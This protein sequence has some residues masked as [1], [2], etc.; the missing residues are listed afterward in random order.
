MAEEYVEFS[1]PTLTQPPQVPVDAGDEGYAKSLAPRHIGMI[2]IGGAIGTG[3]LLG[4]GGKLAIVGP[5]LALSYA[6]AGIFAYLVVRALLG[7]GH[8]VDGGRPGK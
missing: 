4:A 2:A 5:G 1:T 7:S 8:P 6:I 3:L